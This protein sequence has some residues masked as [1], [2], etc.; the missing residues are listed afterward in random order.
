[1]AP[2][3]DIVSVKVLDSNNS[4]NFLSE[5]VAGLD[6]VL[7]NPQ[8]NV[9]IINM[10]LGTFALFEGN[11]DSIFPTAAAAIDGL[12]NSGVISFVSAGNSSSGTS[13]GAP[14]CIANS[15]S[16]GATDDNDIV[17]TFSNSNATTDIFAPGVS[18][19]SSGLGGGTANFIW[20]EYG[21]STCSRLRCP[22][23]TGW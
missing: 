9:Q 3:A 22:A 13:M 17:A 11:C 15:I 23:Y 18:I 5:I 7:T 2:N 4:F 21:L 10:S 12:R 19:I 20:N 16:V 8:F 14:A 1:M 6:F